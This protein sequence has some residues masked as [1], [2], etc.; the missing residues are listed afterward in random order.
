MRSLILTIF[1][2]ACLAFSAR[3]VAA[4]TSQ[5]GGVAYA[6]F[7]AF[8]ARNHLGGLV[9]L[10]GNTAS[11]HPQAVPAFSPL[12]SPAGLGGLQKEDYFRV[13][14]ASGEL[15]F[16]VESRQFFFNG[17]RHWLSFPLR[18][19]EA[20][21]L[22]I[23]QVD[24]SQLLEV[25][26]NGRGAVK[27]RKFEGVVID[28]GHGGSNRGAVGRNGVAEKTATLA[29]ANEL[30]RLLQADGVSVV[31][32]RSG[33]RYLGLGA[34]S[35]IAN[36]HKNHLFV[37][38]HYN[39][40]R[41]TSHG[42][43]TYALTPQGAASVESA[44]RRSSRDDTRYPGNRTGPE[45]LLL[46]SM[47]QRELCKHHSPEGDRGVKWARFKVLRDT[48]MPAILVEAGFLS[49]AVD[50]PLIATESYRNKIA[51][52]I[53]RGIKSFTATMA[54]GPP[55]VAGTQ[56]AAAVPA[57]RATTLADA[58]SHEKPTAESMRRTPA[59]AVGRTLNP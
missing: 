12:G 29:T 42:V 23:S 24:E 3:A 38:I 43:E 26:L 44:G 50:A 54:D 59:H 53:A 52:A 25:L 56:I 8:C 36:R 49:H 10:S 22:R 5:I 18:R 46:A 47:V 45:S 37:S 33:D 6:A 41:S 4:G 1:V 27:G 31:M 7:D 39:M 15:V 13:S 57:E 48:E 19:T 14:G 58:Q 11:S 20:G 32:T 34:R 28:A 55:P 17:A 16:R 9:K 30:K 40:G 21:E 51:A 35:S 2:G